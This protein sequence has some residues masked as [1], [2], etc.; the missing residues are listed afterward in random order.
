VWR[1]G[2][3]FSRSA[4][5]PE[6]QGASRLCGLKPEND[7]IG[8]KKG[9]QYG[10]RE[11]VRFFTEDVQEF[12]PH[13]AGY[14]LIATHFFL[15]CFNDEELAE[16]M[17]LIANWRKTDARWVV[18]EFCEGQAMICQLWTRALIRSLYA[19]FWFTTGLRVT[20]LPDHKAALTGQGF[21]LRFERSALRGL[22]H[23]S[24]WEN[25][26]DARINYSDRHL[27]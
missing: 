5:V 15:D 20:R 17:A 18:S 10:F 1:W 24:L 22:L 11:R 4:T 13:P 8:G 27:T 26:S 25:R 14:D 3:P 2:R 23:S 6:S 9:K 7:R 12:E 16:V 21:S 19:A